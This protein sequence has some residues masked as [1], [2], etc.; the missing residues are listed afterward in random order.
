MPR[1]T[2]S[3]APAESTTKVGRTSTLW[4]QRRD[5]TEASLACQSRRPH[6]HPNQHAEAELKLIRD[7]RRRN[8]TLG[9]IKL[10]HLLRAR[11]YTRCPES[12]FRAMQRLGMFPDPKPKKTYKP[13]PYEQMTHPGKRVQVDVKVILAVASQPLIFVCFSTPLSTSSRGCAFSPP[14][15]SNLLTP[16]RI[17][18]AS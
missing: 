7:M 2:A 11:G 18:F 3:A 4:K 5:G 15:R 13:K 1:N 10:W 8:P 12:L 16:Q 9:M 17:S 6:G 14:T